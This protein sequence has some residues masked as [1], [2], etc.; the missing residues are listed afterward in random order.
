MEAEVAL[1]SCCRE[2]IP[3]MGL[4]TEIVDAVEMPSHDNPTMH[5]T[6]HKDNSGALVLAK[7]LLPQF[8]P[9]SKYYAIKTN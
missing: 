7:T 5:V 1:A 8:T 2:L 9:Q 6:I 4:V 3:I